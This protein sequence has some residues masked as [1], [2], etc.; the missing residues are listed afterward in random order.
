MSSNSREGSMSVM[1]FCP[2]RRAGRA[3]MRNLLSLMYLAA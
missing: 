2:R 3:A 1:L